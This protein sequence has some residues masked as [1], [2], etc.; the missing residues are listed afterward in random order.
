MELR[1]TFL[2]PT[3]HIFLG[4]RLRMYGFLLHA[5]ETMGVESVHM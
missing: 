1:P 4:I 3:G 2:F 5:F